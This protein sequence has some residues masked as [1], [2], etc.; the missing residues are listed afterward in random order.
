MIYDPTTMDKKGVLG[1]FVGRTVS[2]YYSM[3]DSSNDAVRLKNLIIL[4]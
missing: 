2:K 3:V 4:T 1:K